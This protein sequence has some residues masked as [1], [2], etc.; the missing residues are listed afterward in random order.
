PRELLAG[1]PGIELVEPNGWEICC[2]SA[3]LYNLLQVEAAEE[4]G[5]QKAERLIATGAEAIAAANPGCTL[6][7]AAHLEALGHPLPIFHPVE[8]LSRSIKP[9]L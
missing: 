4:L 7:I 8:L 5:R 9:A 3:G 2:G 6:Q 1:I